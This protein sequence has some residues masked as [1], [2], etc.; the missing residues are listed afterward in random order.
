MNI[1]LIATLYVYPIQTALCLAALFPLSMFLVG[2]FFR[3]RR[4]K[5]LSQ[6]LYRA[7]ENPEECPDIIRHLLDEPVLV[8]EVLYEAC[9]LVGSREGVHEIRKLLA[10]RALDTKLTRSC[11]PLLDGLANDARQDP[12]VA[13]LF[14]GLFAFWQPPA[15]ES[16]HYLKSSVEG[17]WGIVSNALLNDP[18]FYPYAL[19]CLMANEQHNA[20]QDFSTKKAA[21]DELPALLGYIAIALHLQSPRL[22]LLQRYLPPAGPILEWALDTW[23][24]SKQRVYTQNGHKVADR[25][26]ESMRARISKLPYGFEAFEMIQVLVKSSAENLDVAILAQSICGVS[27]QEWE[28]IIKAAGP[29]RWLLFLEL[30]KQDPDNNHT[31]KVLNF[32]SVEELD[33]H[34]IQQLCSPEIRL[35]PA[36]IASIF[37]K[38]M[39]GQDVVASFQRA[40]YPSERL[41][42][43]PLS[44]PQTIL[45]TD[46]MKKSYRFQ[47]GMPSIYIINTKFAEKFKKTP[48][49]LLFQILEEVMGVDEHS[50]DALVRAMAHYMEQHATQEEWDAAFFTVVSQLGER[51]EN[52]ILR[53]SPDAI[54]TLAENDSGNRLLTILKQHPQAEILFPRIASEASQESVRQDAW[55][56]GASLGFAIPPAPEE[57]ETALEYAKYISTHG[58]SSLHDEEVALVRR[59]LRP[60]SHDVLVGYGQCAPEQLKDLPYNSPERRKNSSLG[61]ALHNI[62]K[63]AFSLP[64]YPELVEKAKA[65]WVKL[66]A[67]RSDLDES[68]ASFLSFVPATNKDEVQE[69]A[70]V[71]QGLSPQRLVVYR[72]AMSEELCRQLARSPQ[73][74]PV[75]RANVLFQYIKFK[76]F[77]PSKCDVSQ[78]T[79]TVAQFLRLVSPELSS[80]MMIA[81][82]KEKQE[83]AESQEAKILG[84]VVGVAVSVVLR[85]PAHP[86]D[87]DEQS[88]LFQIREQ[89]K[90]WAKSKTLAEVVEKAF[91]RL[92]NYLR[93]AKKGQERQEIGLPIVRTWIEAAGFLGD[94]RVIDD[95]KGIKKSLSE[96][97]LASLGESLQFALEECPRSSNHSV[98]LRVTQAISALIVS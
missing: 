92:W 24:L 41:P 91:H 28:A 1:F 57:L 25:F 12:S 70:T 74:T 6:A 45:V 40:H 15:H 16:K 59:L 30:L 48:A 31:R 83:G 32:F 81:S 19:V 38:T 23:E 5:E 96:D 3:K 14:Q 34:R 42:R 58:R 71:L 80:W 79:E 7:Q 94:T 47:G 97:E 52:W 67:Q 4:I 87:F 33:T 56:I 26:L 54:I 35:D 37:V 43:L 55:R 20:I 88:S 62:W 90:V 75:L 9:V 49:G 60:E 44:A 65:L 61:G 95:L 11:V 66:I 39:N 64:E 89:L 76:S 29:Q 46:E 10:Q 63:I 93:K 84:F 50:E 18:V 22:N 21:Q 2:E 72:D 17:V 13:S 98:S 8:P 27:D 69:L 78:D 51:L 85:H 86:K 68:L 82:R 36:Q 53:V 73:T 77:E